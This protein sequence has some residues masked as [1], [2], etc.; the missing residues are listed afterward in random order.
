MTLIIALNSILAFG[1]I[2]MVVSPLVWA[3]LTQHRDHV[4]V[5]RATARVAADSPHPRRRPQDAPM[6]RRADIA[7]ANAS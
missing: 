6:R 7:A 4:A 3:I 5:A 2:V 1:V